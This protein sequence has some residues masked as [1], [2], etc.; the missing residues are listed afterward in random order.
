MRD[1]RADPAN[2]K[3]APSKVLQNHLR[4]LYSAR[5]GTAHEGRIAAG[6]R[7]L[8]G[9]EEPVIEHLAQNATPTI[10]ARQGHAV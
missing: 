2:R 7:S 3:A 10:T 1:R 9:Q 5:K 6:C 4:R 8:T